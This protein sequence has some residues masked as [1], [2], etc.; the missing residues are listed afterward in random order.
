MLLNDLL[1]KLGLVTISISSSDILKMLV[2]SQ[3][4]RSFIVSNKRE[5]EKELEAVNFNHQ[6]NHQ[7]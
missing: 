6:V 4:S 5:Y 7:D 2:L 1:Y 3:N